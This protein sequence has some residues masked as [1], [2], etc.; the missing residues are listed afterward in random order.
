MARVNAQSIVNSGGSVASQLA[1]LYD[2]LIS[3]YQATSNASRWK[4]RTYSGDPQAGSVVARRFANSVSQDYG[5]ARTSG[6][7]NK[8]KADDIVIPVNVHKEIIEEVS[9]NDL[10][11]F[12]VNGIVAQRFTNFEM[13]MRAE[14]DRAY[15]TQAKTEGTQ[16]N[17]QYTT[18][19]EEALETIIQSVETLSTAY[20]DGVDRALIKVALKPSIYGLIRQKL[21][22]TYNFNGTTAENNIGYYHGVEV[23]SELY[24]PSGV[25][26][27]VQVDEAIAEPVYSEGF[28]DDRIPLSNDHAV[29]LFYDY[30]VKAVTPDA[31]KYGTITKKTA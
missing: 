11:R 3:N 19:V 1:E 10:K 9:Q 25:D 12:G 29:E 23:V 22:F 30:G 2:G 14:L 5:T 27:V 20:I 4:N 15:W 24:L 31:I 13:R 6:K 16:T 8:V 18:D 26:Y 7:G 21:D 17:V 28:Q